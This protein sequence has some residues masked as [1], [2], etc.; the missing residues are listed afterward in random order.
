[1]CV[2]L[3]LFASLNVSGYDC[4]TSSQILN[5]SSECFSVLLRVCIFLILKLVLQAG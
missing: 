4:L 5:D 2:Q 1:M 3:I